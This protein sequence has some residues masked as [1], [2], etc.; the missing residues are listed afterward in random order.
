[1]QKTLLFSLIISLSIFSNC[2]NTQNKQ[3]E[4][5]AGSCPC[6][7]VQLYLPRSCYE[8]PEKDDMI[9]FY[10]YYHIDLAKKNADSI[11]TISVSEKTNLDSLFLVLD[12]YSESLLKDSLENEKWIG[13]SMKIPQM[14]LTIFTKIWCN[15][16]FVKKMYNTHLDLRYDEIIVF[17]GNKNDEADYYRN[18]LKLYHDLSEKEYAEYLKHADYDALKNIEHLNNPR[19]Y[20]SRYIFE[21]SPP[22]DTACL[23]QSDT[24]IHFYWDNKRVRLDSLEHAISHFKREFQQELREVQISDTIQGNCKE[25]VFSIH[26]AKNIPLA[27]FMQIFDIAWKYELACNIDCVENRLNIR[28]LCYEHENRESQRFYTPCRDRE[29]T[30]H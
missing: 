20:M 15:N 11:I 13:I 22:R 12:T 19:K 27:E 21:T 2:S 4:T 5:A 1:M 30:Y 6:N 25:N 26:F 3:I 9:Q 14:P 23:S 24:I 28:T 17:F 10:S 29:A 18:K 8:R 16:I 7:F